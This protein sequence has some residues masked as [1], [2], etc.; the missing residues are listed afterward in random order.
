MLQLGAAVGDGVGVGVGSGVGDGDAVGVAVGRAV[1]VEVARGVGVSVGPATAEALGLASAVA[2]ASGEGDRDGASDASGEGDGASGRR[3]LS[4]PPC[5]NSNAHP[6]IAT[7][8]T[9]PSRDFRVMASSSPGKRG[10]RP[11]MRT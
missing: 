9:T 5:P 3:P 10:S 6:K 8:T 11:G 2:L 7:N 1:G 4:Q